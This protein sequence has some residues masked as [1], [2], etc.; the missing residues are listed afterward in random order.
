MTNLTKEAFME[1]AGEF[2]EK[3]RQELDDKSQDFY[4][5]ESKLDELLT[6][7]GQEVLQE[8]LGKVSENK[9]KKKKLQTRFGKIE[10]KESHRYSES[11]NGY[12]ISPYL[13]ERLVLSGQ[14]EVYNLCTELISKFL[15]IETNDMQIH[16]VTNTYG[17]LSA[18]LVGE[19]ESASLKKGLEKD[20]RVYVEADGSMVLTRE[21]K[22]KE[23]KVGRIFKE[24]S[25][26]QVSE[27]RREVR[28][29]LYAAHLGGHEDFLAKFEPMVDAL[30]SLQ[31]NLVFV[32]DGASWLR[33]WISDNYPK[34][35]Q[36]LD[37]TH[38][39]D[40]ISDWLNYVEKESTKRQTEFHIYKK[41]LLE[42]GV[43]A[44]IDRVEKTPMRLKTEEEERRKLLNYL[45]TNAYRMN[46]PQYIEQGICI[47]SGAIEAAH[48]TI[49]Q[50]RMK[51][52]GQ[53][54]SEKR[55]QNMLNLKVANLS[56]SW[57]KI[58]NIIRK[59]KMAA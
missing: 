12:R 8:S 35:L 15:R 9:R 58:V 3:L 21:D 41:L 40:H 11:V 4:E 52:S 14:S 37:F 27:K 36:V 13:Q 28:E 32:T 18:G 53:R 25:L 44:V 43:A 16:R 50:K 57:D 42:T 29:S 46:Y 59:P 7:F 49:V 5:Y 20:E 45:N 22:W 26:L 1:K 51:L 10:I 17:E 38:A 34:A 6:Q 31:S 54:W 55:V 33:L 47:G 2:Y 24:S 23:V 30:D 56:G 19:S 48:R 39:T